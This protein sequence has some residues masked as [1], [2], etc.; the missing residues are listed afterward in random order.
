[1]TI[2]G[3]AMMQNVERPIETE[4][5][6][7]L[8]RRELVARLLG[9]LIEP[10]GRAT[11][12]VLGL[13]GPGGSG[14]SSILNMVAERAEAHYPAAVV[15]MFNPWL[16]N[17]RSGSIHAFFAEVTAALEASAEKPGCA[18]PERIKGLA[19]TIFNYGKRVAPAENVWLC[20]GGTA[21]AGLDRL[22]Q[23][24]PGRD[25]LRLMRA[26]LADEL[27]ESGIA[28]VVLIDEIDRLDDS[29]VAV[30]A[31]LV[32]AIADFQ[33]VSYLLAYDADRVAQALGK[34]EIERGR[35]CLEKLIQ[36]QVALPSILPRQIRRIVELRFRELVDDLDEHRQR[37][38]Q[39]LGI[40]T[41]AILSTVR[42]A[43]RMLGGFEVLHRLL[44]LE[45]DEIDLLGWAAILAKYPV[46]EQA[47]RRRQ[48]QIIGPANHLFGEALLDRMVTGGRPTAVDVAVRSEPGAP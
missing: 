17:S 40:L 19:Q 43:K 45:V 12:V 30:V 15:V 1:M 21:A 35:A 16:A 8:L 13:A 33:Q 36:L 41:P 2:T 38:T 7:R 9:A 14:K 23:R 27:I 18:H 34:G 31:R 39:L 5:D 28:I 22:Q 6:D 10:E 26:Q 48:D 20:D 42:H 44:R 25:S 46:V 37:L 29:E 47:L 24:L 4:R 11:G 32:G 3:G